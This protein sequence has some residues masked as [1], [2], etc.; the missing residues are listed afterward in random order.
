VI[1]GITCVEVHDT[2]KIDGKLR[3]DTRD[4]F[5]QDKDGNVWYF[6]E[7]TAELDATGHVTSREGSWQAGVDG[8]SKERAGLFHLTALAHPASH[9]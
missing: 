2:S 4:W 3:E 8:A 7:D 6:G 9:P 5:A 1:L